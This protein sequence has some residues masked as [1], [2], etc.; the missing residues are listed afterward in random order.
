MT[1][2]IGP[3]GPPGPKG[4]RGVDTTSPFLLG[5]IAANLDRVHD[6]VVEIKSIVK[7]HAEWA[8]RHEK[9]DDERF[10]TIA[11]DAAVAKA[12]AQANDARVRRF[13]GF[14]TGAVPVLSAGLA[15]FLNKLHLTH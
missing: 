12:L 9:S 13:I 6:D 8:A 11:T 3:Q 1:D 4:E 2:T 14:A 15:Y 5:Q 10:G 7:E